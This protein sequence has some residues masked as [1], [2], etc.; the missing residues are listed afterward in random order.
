MS[1]SME[2]VSIG[3]IFSQMNLPKMCC[4]LL[5]N[6]SIFHCDT[7]YCQ[8]MGL[9]LQSLNSTCQLLSFTP[10]ISQDHSSSCSSIIHIL[11]SQFQNNKQSASFWQVLEFFSQQM[12]KLCGCGSRQSNSS[13]QHSHIIRRTAFWLNHS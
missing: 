12:A 8:F 11:K 7:H 1:Y 9:G 2:W 5:E 3:R 4:L 13:I 10:F 6:Y